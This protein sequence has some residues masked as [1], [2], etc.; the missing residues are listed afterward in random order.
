[1]K[2]RIISFPAQRLSLEQPA[3]MIG[4]ALAC[5]LLMLHAST[6]AHEGKRLS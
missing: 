4:K 6:A 5:L 3:R 1:M 2:S